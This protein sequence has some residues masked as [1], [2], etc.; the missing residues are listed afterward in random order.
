MGLRTATFH[1]DLENQQRAIRSNSTNVTSPSIFAIDEGV[2][3][4]NDIENKFIWG[5]GPYFSHRLFNPDLPLSMETELKFK[6][7]SSY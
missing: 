6:Q 7:A 4:E 2:S 3:P 1:V 5:V